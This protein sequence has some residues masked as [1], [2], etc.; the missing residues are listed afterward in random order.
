[1]IIEEAEDA[2]VI[3]EEEKADIKEK[4]LSEMSAPAITPYEPSGRRLK[5]SRSFRTIQEEL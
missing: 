4:L 1:M 5:K 2:E 3:T